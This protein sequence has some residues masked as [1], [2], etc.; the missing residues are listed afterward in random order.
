MKNFTSNSIHC[1]K[2]TVNHLFVSTLFTTVIATCECVYIVVHLLQIY[3]STLSMV[4]HPHLYIVVS[5]FDSNTLQILYMVY[6]N[7]QIEIP[8]I[9]GTMISVLLNISGMELLQLVLWLLMYQNA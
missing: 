1:I 7:Q 6:D 5:H 8:N 9:H 2:L 4:L 3:I